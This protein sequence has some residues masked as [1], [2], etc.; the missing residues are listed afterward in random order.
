MSPR[1]LGPRPPSATENAHAKE[2]EARGRAADERDDKV[3]PTLEGFEQTARERGADAV[4]AAG[5][6]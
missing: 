4:T 5:R 2:R 3:P 1:A 6:P